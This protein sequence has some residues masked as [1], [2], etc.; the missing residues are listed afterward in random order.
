MFLQA[1]N[2]NENISAPPGVDKDLSVTKRKVLAENKQQLVTDSAEAVSGTQKAVVALEQN[3]P[4][5]AISIWQMVSGKLDI[6]LAKVPA[7]IETDIFDFKGDAKAI[8]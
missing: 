6:I 7:D 8:T 5:T 1:L 4:K 2:K 3:D